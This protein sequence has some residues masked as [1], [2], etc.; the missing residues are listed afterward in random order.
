MPEEAI[1]VW[2]CVTKSNVTT[3]ILFFSANHHII[4]LTFLIAHK[5]DK[6]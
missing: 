2:S 5:K 4:G 6:F 3:L 1:A